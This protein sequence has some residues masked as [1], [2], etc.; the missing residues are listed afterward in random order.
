MVPNYNH[1]CY[2]QPWQQPYPQPYQQPYQLPN[3][4]YLYNKY[5]PI[6]RQFIKWIAPL[7]FVVLTVLTG[8]V[9]I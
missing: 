7:V 5:M 8:F 4:N 1:D 2:C 9:I 6:L 3:P